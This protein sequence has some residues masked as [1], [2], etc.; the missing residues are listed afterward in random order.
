VPPALIC[1]LPT[2]PVPPSVPPAFTVMVELASVPFTAKVPA[3]MV[4]GSAALLVPVSVQV[5]VPILLK[6]PKPRYC[7]AA[8]IC[9]T[10]NDAVPLPP[11]W[12]VS[13][14]VPSTLPVIAEP[15]AKVSVLPVP[16]KL[17]AA[18]PPLMLPALKT[19]EPPPTLT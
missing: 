8:P 12:K 11:S 9:D 2:V 3:L 1:V 6:V 14:P 18:V 10:S 4:H 5:D 13:L 7:A 17:I 16:A 19:E 15:G